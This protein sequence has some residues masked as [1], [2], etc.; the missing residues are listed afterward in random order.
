[1]LPARLHTT[2]TTFFNMEN[3]LFTP[4]H[5]WNNVEYQMNYWVHTAGRYRSTFIHE[6]V[7][8]AFFN[9][10]QFHAMATMP[11][12]IVL[13][14]MMTA[15]D[16]EFVRALHYHNKGYEIDNDYGL[17]PNITR[18]VCVYSMFSTEASFN[19]AD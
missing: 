8:K 5:L 11:D 15:L 1:M 19:P 7:C 17:P 2:F 16:L 14:R 9:Y 12:E 18:L 3:P 10:Y 4:Y 13:A 6:K